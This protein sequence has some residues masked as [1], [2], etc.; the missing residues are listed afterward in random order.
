MAG[1]AGGTLRAGEYPGRLPPSY[2]VSHQAP[3]G[4]Q[5]HQ[6]DHPGRCPEAVPGCPESWPYPGGPG[7]WTRPVRLQR[8]PS[9]WGAVPGHGR[10]SAGTAHPLES[11]PGRHVA[12]KG[13]SSQK[14]PQ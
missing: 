13:D 10:G 9:P 5:A 1:G 7:V 11:H 2:P 8:P 14:D 3:A 4:Q 6:Q 12:Q